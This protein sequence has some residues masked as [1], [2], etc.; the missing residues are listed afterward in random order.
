MKSITSFNI[1]MW[2]LVLVQ[3]FCFFFF[4]KEIQDFPAR[5]QRQVFDDILDREVQRGKSMVDFLSQLRGLDLTL[6]T[7]SFVRQA[8]YRTCNNPVFWGSFCDVKSHSMP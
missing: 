4:H 2:L 3:P 5:V 8:T 1:D 7:L 6:Y